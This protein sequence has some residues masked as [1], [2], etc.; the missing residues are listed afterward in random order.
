[1][2]VTASF[3]RHEIDESE[4]VALGPSITTPSTG[5]T[6]PTT[7]ETTLPPLPEVALEGGLL[8]DGGIRIK[9]EQ[10]LGVD[11]A[12]SYRPDKNDRTPGLNEV[13]LPANINDSLLRGSL[14]SNQVL[15]FAGEETGRPSLGNI[16]LS[17]GWALEHDQTI[18]KYMA[19]SFAVKL[20]RDQGILEHVPVGQMADAFGQP[21][22]E[23][24][25]SDLHHG[26]SLHNE[27]LVFT[28]QIED[29]PPRGV[30]GPLHITIGCR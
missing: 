19:Y 8:V 20:R 5:N 4:P 2:I 27:S 9:A 30:D 22:Q 23:L 28:A 11:C 12:P 3:I 13:W 10:A 26:I 29:N 17:H 21:L 18:N 24:S 15:F 7:S 6:A 16:K 25:Q 14:G 1:M